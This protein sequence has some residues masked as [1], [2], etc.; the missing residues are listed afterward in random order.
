[1]I[2]E[3]LELVRLLRG[4]SRSV[5]EIEAIRLR[6]L[7]ALVRYAG[8]NVPYYRALFQSVDL[9]PEDIRCVQDLRALPATTRDQLG[10]SGPDRIGRDVDPAT[11]RV[12]MSTGSTGKPW[13]VYRTRAEARLARA[14]EFRAMIA[15]GVHLTD[16]IASL[17][18]TRPIRQTLGRFGICPATVVSLQLS[19]EEQAEH[20]REIRPDVFWVYPTCLRALLQHVG[21]LSSIIRPRLIITSAEPLDDVLRQKLLFDRPVEMR[22]FYGAVEAGRIAWECAAHEGL[23][24]NTDCV[25]IEL[26]DETDVPGA[27]K[28]VVVTNLNSRASPYIRYRLGDRCELIEQ[29]CSCGSSFPLMKAPVGRQWDIIQLPSG[30]LISPWGCSAILRKL[31]NLQQFRV[32]Q[33]RAD[34][35]ILQLKFSVRPGRSLL[36]DVRRQLQQYLGEPVTI[37]IKL[38]DHFDNEALKFRA[39]ISMLAS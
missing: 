14:L 19:I 26:E 28:S 23:H 13:L 8:E 25:I 34:L 31:E 18:P 6:K 24:I 12:I 20:L 10:V 22:N 4:S 27:G 1:M 11:C 33:E 32:I 15:A 37:R 7:K 3:H 5:D 29:P 36:D 2:S 9:A 38:I 30:G 35:L 16:R 21:S 39:F 17:G